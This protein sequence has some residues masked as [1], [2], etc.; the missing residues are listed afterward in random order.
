[1]RENCATGCAKSE[2][3][4]VYSSIV[5]K[6]SSVFVTEGLVPGC[7]DIPILVREGKQNKQEHEVFGLIHMLNHFDGYT[8]K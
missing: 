5:M 6:K 3:K 4:F 8:E 7:Q 2:R 1:M